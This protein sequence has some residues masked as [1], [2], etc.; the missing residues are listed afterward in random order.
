MKSENAYRSP[1]SNVEKSRSSDELRALII[2]A[3]RQK[4]LLYAF[5]AYL[6]ISI[7][8]SNP[9]EQ[10]KAIGSLLGIPIFLAIVVLNIR[11][12]WVLYGPLGRFFAIIFGIVPLVNFI[13]IL[14]ASSKAN[15]V[16]KKA[17]IKVG[18]MGAN[19]SQL[20]TT[21]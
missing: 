4:H 11:L 16:L 14:I 2:I 19:L 18:L 13:V 12:S 6:V 17:G 20:K 15:G 9:D 7:L 5:L 10:L 3:K 21:I 1:E 8:V